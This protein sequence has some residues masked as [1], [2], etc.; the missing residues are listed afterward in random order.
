MHGQECRAKCC[1]ALDAARHRIADVVQLEI[2]E[3]LLAGV[4]ELTDQRQAAGISEL[5]ADL[6]KCNAVAEPRDHR[7]R[8]RDA[9]QIERHNQPV[10]G[11]DNRRLHVTS[12]HALGNVDQLPHQRVERLD[13][14]RML[15]SIHIIIGLARE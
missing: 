11:S 5:I 2:D 6:V 7:F 10:A 9:G 13:I 8:S 3:N 12:H 1:D 15:Q 14:G 4:R